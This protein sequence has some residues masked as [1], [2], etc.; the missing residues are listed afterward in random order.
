MNKLRSLLKL[1]LITVIVLLLSFYLLSCLT[2]YINPVYWS[3]FT[4]LALLFPYSFLLAL[5]GFGLSVVLFRK[6]IKYCI[7]VFG[8]LLIGYK[9]IFATIGFHRS[10]VFQEKKEEGTIRLLSWNVDDF[11]KCDKALDKP[12]NPRRNILEFIK[13]ANADIICFQDYRNF[14]ENKYIYSNT[15]FMVDTLKYPYHYFSVDDPCIGEYFACK[16]GTMIYSKFPIIDSGR[17]AY[18]WEH[19]P[20]HLMYATVNVNGKLVRF[21]NTHLR[22]MFLHRFGKIPQQNYKFVI[23][24]TAIIYYGHRTEKLRY[25]DL[26]HVKQAKLI[27]EELNKSPEPFVFCADLNSVPSSYVYQCI[28][29]GLNDA[30]LQYG[31]GWGQTYSGFSPTLR[32]DV[33]LM[34]KQI[35]AK[36]YYCPK[37]QNASDHYPVI[38]DLLIH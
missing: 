32:I 21:Y 18:N 36:Q 8:I 1:A 6:K 15:K 25:F 35:E 33:T 26:I 2:P 19:L 38:T 12:K 7:I 28:S 24:D 20:E 22:S 9:N 17:V 5:I 11:V 23:D 10:K 4:Y 13:S 31:N 30:F 34:S 16:Y 27:K 29:N 3:G 37:L 14:E